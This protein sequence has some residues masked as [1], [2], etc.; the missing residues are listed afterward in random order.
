MRRKTL[1]LSA[2]ALVTTLSACSGQTGRTAQ[3]EGD[4]GSGDR[5]F[6]P[7]SSI[8]ALVSQASD[9]A[10]A[11]RTVTFTTKISGGPAALDSMPPNTCQVDIAKSMMSC[12]GAAEMVVTQD[13]MYVKMP[14]PGQKPW[15]KI[16]YR[17]GGAMSQ[18]MSKVSTFKRF[19]EFEKMLPKGSTITGTKRTEVNGKAATRYDVTVDPTKLPK[20][21]NQLAQLGQDVMRKNGITEL[22]STFWVSD[23]GLPLKYTTTVPPMTAMGREIPEITTT[24]TYSDWGK[25]VEITVPPASKVGEGVQMPKIPELPKQPN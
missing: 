5:A 7:V 2:L 10:D 11:Q 12:D 3:P 8:S 4:Q 9:S 15:R 13:A 21:S 6:K 20:S 23:Q 1:A 24:V 17:S 22:H 14:V 18:M 19:T 25:P 16:S